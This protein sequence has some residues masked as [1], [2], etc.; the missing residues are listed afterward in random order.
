[1]IRISSKEKE[2]LV[3]KLAASKHLY[4]LSCL[5]DHRLMSLKAFS[6]LGD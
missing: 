2:A 1:V 6:T 3:K 4:W 5:E